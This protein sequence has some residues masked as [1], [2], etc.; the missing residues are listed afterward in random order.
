MIKEQNLP[1][2]PFE[3]IEVFNKHAEIQTKRLE[4]EE[5]LNPNYGLGEGETQILGRKELN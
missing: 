2:D 3:Q 4:E 5:L 1:Q